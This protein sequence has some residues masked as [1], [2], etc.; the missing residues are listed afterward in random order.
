MKDMGPVHYFL[1]IQVHHTSDGLF[2]NQE[3]YGMDLLVT[4]GMADCLLCQ[5]LF[6]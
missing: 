4:A 5:L 6:H 3:K 2:M 1:G